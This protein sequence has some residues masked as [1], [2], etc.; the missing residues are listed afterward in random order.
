MRVKIQ[1]VRI[2]QKNQNRYQSAI[3]AAPPVYPIVAVPLVELML[4]VL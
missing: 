4:A 3:T 1:S 2:M